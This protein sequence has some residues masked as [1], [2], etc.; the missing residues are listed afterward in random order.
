MIEPGKHKLDKYI[1]R[2]IQRLGME[3]ELTA[4]TIADETMK[5]LVPG[6][7]EEVKERA[8]FIMRELC[9]PAAI[10]EELL[11]AAKNGPLSGNDERRLIAAGSRMNAQLKG[12]EAEMKRRHGDS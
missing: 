8:A 7:Y 10:V 12:L 5:A 6:S 3:R 1:D 4:G 9:D 11:A 2:A